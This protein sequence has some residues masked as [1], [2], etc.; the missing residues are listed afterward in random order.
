MRDFLFIGHL[1]ISAMSIVKNLT[2]GKIGW[3]LVQTLALSFTIFG[4]LIFALGT[5]IFLSA[6]GEG[7]LDSYLKTDVARLLFLGAF[8]LPSG[9]ILLVQIGRRL[10]LK[11][12]EHLWTSDVRS[13][14]LYLRPFAAD[15]QLGKAGW[16][17]LDH[18]GPFTEEEQLVEA[19]SRVGPVVALG[20]PGELLPRIGARR[21]YVS[22]ENWKVRVE[23]LMRQAQLVVVLY[24]DSSSVQWEIEKAQELLRPDQLVIAFLKADIAAILG[25]SQV[26]KVRGAIG[27]FRY[28]TGDWEPVHVALSK[29]SV[30]YRSIFKG[31]LGLFNHTLKP[32]ICRWL[33]DPSPPIRFWNPFTGLVAFAFL[34]VPAKF[35][36]AFLVAL[37]AEEL[38]LVQ[39][40]PWDLVSSEYDISITFPSI[41]SSSEGF[42]LGYYFFAFGDYPTSEGYC[43]VWVVPHDKPTVEDDPLERLVEPLDLEFQVR[44]IDVTK[45]D[46]YIELVQ[47]ID[48]NPRALYAFPYADDEWKSEGVLMLHDRFVVQVAIHYEASLDPQSLNE[49]AQCKES[50]SLNAISDD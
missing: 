31:K 29:P 3:R 50:F 34:S 40:E 11:A 33:N 19:L 37:I 4:V 43:T 5:F 22:Q 35:V 21:E 27:G 44:N 18:V 2:Y 24:A 25:S 23:D 30:A 13:M 48:G 47:D 1:I 26:K 10:R 14:V 49:L 45:Y 16:R 8:L 38:N 39:H 9:A 6:F 20:Q 41:P 12:R 17:F 42:G 32:V 7:V 28:Y 36:T 15:S 46:F